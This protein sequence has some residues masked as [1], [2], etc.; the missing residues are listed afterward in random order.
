[1]D[2]FEEKLNA[3]LASPEA[4]GQL[5]SRADSLSGQ[6]GEASRPEAEPAPPAAHPPAALPHLDP[7]LLG[8]AARLLQAYRQRDD[9]KTALLLALRPF[10]RQERQ[11]RLERAVQL[12]RLSRVIRTALGLFREAGHV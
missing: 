9:D 3:I 6:T 4:M 12:T 10:L 7:A 11:A 8:T 1:M 2:D 5:M